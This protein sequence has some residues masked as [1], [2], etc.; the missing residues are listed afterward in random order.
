LFEHKLEPRAIDWTPAYT[1]FG[2][3]AG[4]KLFAATG[5]IKNAQELEGLL[6]E[7]QQR[8]IPSHK[9][10]EHIQYLEGPRLETASVHFAEYLQTTVSK[11]IAK[12]IAVTDSIAKLCHEL[13]KT[14]LSH[15]VV[16]MM[17]SNVDIIKNR[18]QIVGVKLCMSS[19]TVNLSQYDIKSS[20]AF[21]HN[22]ARLTSVEI[23]REGLIRPSATE[24][25]WMYTPSFYCRA[26]A[27]QAQDDQPYKVALL[28]ACVKAKKFSSYS[29]IF[30]P[31]CIFGKAH[32][33]QT[34]QVGIDSGGTGADHGCILFHDAIHNRRDKRWCFRS[35]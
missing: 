9:Y 27:C 11:H 5:R 1:L 17:F 19:P 34:S 20:F 28:E 21:A 33:R 22:C 32:S 18:N 12:H 7:R 23:L 13:S 8:Y 25:P 31:M 15:D 16:S 10:I 29:D 30:R 26:S 2:Q 6:K 24:P 3:R 35:H 4:Q 14:V